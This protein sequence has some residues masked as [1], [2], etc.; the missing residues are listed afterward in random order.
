MHFRLGHRAL[1]RGCGT[2]IRRV[3]R[4]PMAQRRAA[5]QCHA[6]MGAEA[7]LEH[8]RDQMAVDSLGDDQ[9]RGTR[10]VVEIGCADECR[11]Q[12]AFSV[13]RNSGV[14]QRVVGCQCPVSQ[15]GEEQG[16][17][18]IHRL[19]AVQ[20]IA[21]PRFQR[22]DLGPGRVQRGVGQAIHTA[23]QALRVRTAV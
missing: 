21:H 6:A 17:Q 13:T 1:F 16:R 14:W 3:A 11:R 23:L 19:V 8:V 7:A 5:Q 9:G 4:R 22:I 20:R 10:T 12:Q 15:R 2:S 18:A